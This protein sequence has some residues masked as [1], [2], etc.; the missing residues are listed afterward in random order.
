LRIPSIDSPIENISGNLL[1]RDGSINVQN[2]EADLGGG[3]VY[4]SGTIELFTN[5]YP[6]LNLKGQLAGNR[7]RIFPFQFI[8][9]SG[10]VDVTGGERPY[11][12]SGVVKVDGAMIREKILGQKQTTSSKTLPY[13]PS[14]TGKPGTADTD[15]PFL[16]LKIDISADHGIMVDNDLFQNAEFKA[17]VIL[18][19]TLDSPALLGT[20]E[21]VQG[22]LVFK[23]RVFQIQ[24]AGAKFE[25]PTEIDPTFNL[26]ATAE[27]GSTKVQLYATGTKENLKLEFTSTP[28]LAE[29]EILSL[30]AI[31]GT[32]TQSFQYNSI[33][34]SQLQQGEA[35][36]ML[37]QSMDFNRDFQDKTGF[38]I[39]LDESINP[40]QGL[41]IFNAKAPSE[42][43]AEPKIILKRR[44]G[45]RLT[46]SYGSTVGVG[47]DKESDFNAEYS[48][49]PG[50][51]AIGVYENYETQDVNVGLDNETSYGIDLK[52]QKRFK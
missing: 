22:K 47:T 15:V 11:L 48:L 37:L 32:G 7:F 24:S 16:R 31:G 12:L 35:A 14:S 43:T 13:S 17:H 49:T 41:S 18:V 1:L 50:L 4:T 30:L 36:S 2:L 38:E 8:K 52:L 44:V 45:Q 20:A 10:S 51:S 27:V 40:L 29:S 26:T 25:T 3:R 23:D 33:D 19:N 5:K 39:Q 21:L 46:L 9:L 6:T 34:R 42:E 28:A